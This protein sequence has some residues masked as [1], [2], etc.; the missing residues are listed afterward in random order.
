[1]Q[2]LKHFTRPNGV[3]GSNNSKAFLS[4]SSHRVSQSPVAN[5]WSSTSWRGHFRISR[6]W[7]ANFSVSFS[8]SFW[9]M[10][11]KTTL[12]HCH[13]KKLTQ[14][15]VTYFL[16]NQFQS[17]Y[18]KLWL[19]TTNKQYKTRKTCNCDLFKTSGIAKVWS[20]W[21]SWTGPPRTTRGTITFVQTHKSAETN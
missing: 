21:T 14:W 1:M 18:H 6:K 17:K 10:K 11:G 8:S 12:L 15:T 5:R 7:D 19:P 20:T 3:D 2:W 16:A 13:V 9:I 4:I